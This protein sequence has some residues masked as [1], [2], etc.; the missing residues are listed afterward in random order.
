MEVIPVQ[1]PAM[2]LLVLLLS[3]LPLF[4]VTA[5]EIIKGV[6]H[7][8]VADSGYSK[9]TMSV[10]TSRGERTMEMESWNIG[11]DKSF[12]KILYPKKDRGITF[13][14]IDTTMWQYVPKIEKTIK[15]PSS[16]MMQSWMGSDFTNDDMAKESSI[17]D[18][19][20][21]V[22]SAEDEATYT[23]TLTPRPDA[24][25]VWGSIVM[26]VAKEHFVPLKAVYFD[27][28]GVEQRTLVYSDVRVVDGRY[29]PM[30]MTLTPADKS[31]N[32]TV[33]SMEAV[34]FNARIEE[35]RFTKS[36]LK[37]YSR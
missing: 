26:E 30:V 17:V 14:K 7:N 29:L 15:I 11:H 5:P 37:R 19:Y 2:R 16:M 20:E 10:T 6:E 8:I 12:I 21:A 27:E 36:A 24:A 31:G 23:L 3:A 32:K 35:E 4:A 9:I 25:V 1:R 28:D 18:D 13:L 22:I 33:V 34:D